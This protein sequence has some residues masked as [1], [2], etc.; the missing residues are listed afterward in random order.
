MPELVLSKR[1]NSP[2]NDF[3]SSGSTPTTIRTGG[4]PY[5]FR[6]RGY[7]S[8]TV[9]TF[10]RTKCKLVFCATAKFLTQN[11]LYWGSDNAVGTAGL[12]ATTS[13]LV[14][15]FARKR[16][17]TRRLKHGTSTVVEKET[18]PVLLSVPGGPRMTRKRSIKLSFVEAQAN[19]NAKETMRSEVVETTRTATSSGQENQKAVGPRDTRRR[20]T[21]P[22]VALLE[23]GTTRSE[24]MNKVKITTKTA[25]FTYATNCRVGTVKALHTLGNIGGCWFGGCY[26][27]GPWAEWSHVD[28]DN[29]VWFDRT[30]CN[31]QDNAVVELTSP[32]TFQKRRRKCAFKHCIGEYARHCN[33][34]SACKDGSGSAIEEGRSWIC[35]LPNC[36]NIG[37]D[38]VPEPQEKPVDM[39]S[40]AAPDTSSVIDQLFSSSTTTT[41]TA[42]PNQVEQVEQSGDDSVLPTG[43]REAIAT[44]TDG[45]ANQEPAV[46]GVSAANAATLAADPLA[47]GDG[48]C[49]TA[50]LGLLIAGG[51]LVLLLCGVA[52][53]CC[54]Q[55]YCYADDDF[56][57]EEAEPFAEDGGALGAAFYDDGAGGYDF[58]EEE[59][60]G[61][62]GKSKGGYDS[63][64]GTSSYAPPRGPSKGMGW[65]TKGGGGGKGSKWGGG[66][67]K[68]SWIY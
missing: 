9:R 8:T 23:G 21:A 36:V 47:G 37:A 63:Y 67:G 45:A 29:H 54:R 15:L 16:K 5:P 59:W 7:P 64:Y 31:G 1:V 38:G 43:D 48:P 19:A 2:G 62:K 32:H 20:S 12:A 42:P 34:S 41:T 10:P 57:F 4:R 58:Y 66:Y 49:S 30:E 22:V 11:F 56:F 46:P 33:G 3:S 40:T 53:R 18:D 35:T 61:N 6:S 50:S 28:T 60:Y 27:V 44:V 25:T 65:S 24:L 26:N 13:P 14:K 51:V 17:T 39:T 68:D 52:G 55:E